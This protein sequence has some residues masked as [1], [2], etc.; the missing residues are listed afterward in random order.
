MMHY[1]KFAEM[2]DKEIDMLIRSESEN[3]TEKGQRQLHTLLENRHNVDKWK[4]TA[5]KRYMNPEHAY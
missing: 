4:D 5:G 3:V 1:N 2:L